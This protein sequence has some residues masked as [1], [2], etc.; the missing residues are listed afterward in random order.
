MQTLES[1]PRSGE[2]DD[3][4]SIPDTGPVAA[5]SRDRRLTA[6]ERIHLRLALWLLLSG[7][8]RASTTL[9]RQAHQRRR[10]ETLAAESRAARE[11]QRALL[12]SDR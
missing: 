1:S 3:V 2:V 11:L 4:L 6:A 12:R 9:D 5:A 7:I 10:A 8:R